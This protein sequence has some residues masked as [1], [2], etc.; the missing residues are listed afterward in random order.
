MSRKTVKG[1]H[2]DRKYNLVCIAPD[3][4]HVT[5]LRDATYSECVKRSEDMGSKWIFYPF[6]VITTISGFSVADAFGEMEYFIGKR[7]K[8]LKAAI[9]KGEFNYWLEA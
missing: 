2:F 1:R 5:D 4:D 9:A 8:T 6:H 7:L 3:G